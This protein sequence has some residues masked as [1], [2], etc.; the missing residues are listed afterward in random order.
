M[1]KRAVLLVNLGS[2]AS[3]S[4]ADVRRY[5]R[6]F[7]GDR[8]VLDMPAPLRWLLLEGFI[9]RTRP[10][11]SAHAYA[12]VWTPQGSPLIATSAAVSRKLAAAVGPEAP[13]YLAMRYG[14]PSIGEVV[15]RMN[16]DGI[17]DF[18][19]FPQYPHFA[20]SSW[21]TVTARVDAE[22]R[23]SRSRM[24][25][26]CVRPFYADA[27]YVEALHAVAAP[28]LA[29]PHDLLLFSFHGLP[30]RHLRKADA[31]GRHCMKVADCCNV[32]SPA[33]DTCYRA[34]CLATARALAQRAGLTPGRH[35][36]S[37]QS[38]LAGEPW[39]EPFSDHE[40]LRLPGAGVKRLLVICPSFVVDCLETLE[41]VS[42]AGRRAFLGAGGETFDQ[43]PCLND[44][45]P[46]ID[47]LAG[48][49]R[50]WLAEG[51]V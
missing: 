6:E 22:L 27:D 18:L 43:I 51:R 7:L 23:R 30:V 3:P 41:E 34:Q 38:R 49:V 4:V 36:F 26:S 50:R 8:R 32:P 19:L 17:E 2:P 44:S 1:P 11:R 31:T 16:S 24:R 35:S 21:E 47:F 48:R 39:L 14:R 28:W 25:A 13:V 20:M 10:K 37:F 40:F 5:L 33:H 42:I 46:A 29:R 9:L 45:Q 15:S 12:S